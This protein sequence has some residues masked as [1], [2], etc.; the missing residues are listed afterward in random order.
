MEDGIYTKKQE[1]QTKDKNSINSG[2]ITPFFKVFFH[3]FA[4][5]LLYDCQLASQSTASR[6]AQNPTSLP[7]VGNN[8]YLKH[9]P[10]RAIFSFSRQ[11]EKY[12]KDILKR[13]KDVS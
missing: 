13:N 3:V 10:N 1:N 4:I 5:L 2:K 9:H 6:M 7:A 11:N 12:N 8:A